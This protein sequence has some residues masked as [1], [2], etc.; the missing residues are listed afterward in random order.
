MP[1]GR[2]KRDAAQRWQAQGGGDG[3]NAGG[4]VFRQPHYDI[5]HNGLQPQGKRILLESED[6]FKVLSTAGSTEPPCMDA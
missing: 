1:T 6:C 4:G 2:D 3:D 5:S